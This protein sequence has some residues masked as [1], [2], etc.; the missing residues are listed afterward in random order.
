[1]FWFEFAN[2][3]TMQY[4]FKLLIIFVLATPIIAL[5]KEFESFSQHWIQFDV[6]FLN[7]TK[8]G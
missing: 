6:K 2:T 7:Q 5:W 1:M 4:W 3:D 8:S